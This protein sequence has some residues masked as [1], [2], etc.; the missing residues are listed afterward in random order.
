MG[1]GTRVGSVSTTLWWT[2]IQIDG[3]N[4]FVCAHKKISR[5]DDKSRPDLAVNFKACLFRVGN[6]AFVVQTRQ[7]YRTGKRKAVW[8]K[9]PVEEQVSR[10]PCRILMAGKTEW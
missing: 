6:A 7:P 1:S 3:S 8:L 9:R 4:Q 2:N 10:D 5:L